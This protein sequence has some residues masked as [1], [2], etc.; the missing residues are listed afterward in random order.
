MVLVKCP[1]GFLS[2]LNH[3][4]SLNDLKNICAAAV[5]K[6]TKAWE[7]V[8][9]GSVCLLLRFECQIVGSSVFAG[10]CV[11]LFCAWMSA[12]APSQLQ[13]GAEAVYLP[14]PP[15]GHHASTPTLQV[16]SSP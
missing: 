14:H 3:L 11:V 9:S 10:T 8:F 16:C 13:H 7:L 15:K 5:P 6:C 12:Y 4:Y 2:F 1:L